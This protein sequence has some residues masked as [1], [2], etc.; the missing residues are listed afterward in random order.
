MGT[1]KKLE[2]P[3]HGEEFPLPASQVAP[4]SVLVCTI[5]KDLLL[6]RCFCPSRNFQSIQQTFTRAMA[7]CRL[8]HGDMQG[9]YPSCWRGPHWE[10]S[11]S[12]GAMVGQWEKPG[13]ARNDP[14]QRTGWMGTARGHINCS[15]LR[16][17]VLR[18][19]AHGA[20][21][22][23]G[24]P[25]DSSGSKGMDPHRSWKLSQQWGEASAQWQAPL[26]FA[27]LPPGISKLQHHSHVSLKEA[28]GRGITV[29]LTR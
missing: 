24:V 21:G 5:G 25:E 3:V 16:A 11:R 15:L 14:T 13:S 2:K 19:A 9:G 8:R 20:N 6:K 7:S 4:S 29:V 18:S 27:Q 10:K 28:S 23:Q 22:A 1:T 12:G 26:P 17:K